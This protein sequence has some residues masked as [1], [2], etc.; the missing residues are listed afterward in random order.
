M[1]FEKRDEAE[2]ANNSVQGEDRRQRITENQQGERCSLWSSQSQ[3]D[4]GNSAANGL[5]YRIS[6][7]KDMADIKTDKQR[8]KCKGI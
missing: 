8:S 4:S 3:K 2:S 1:K 7:K 5:S 6:G